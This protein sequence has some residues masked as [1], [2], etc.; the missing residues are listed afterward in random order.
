VAVVRS[1][2]LVVPAV[3]ALLSSACASAPREAPP[4]QAHSAQPA[5]RE[6]AADGGEEG[7]PPSLASAPDAAADAA[8][9]VPYP[10]PDWPTG[11]PDEHG[12][13]VEG[14]AA[15]AAV[16][17]RSQSFCLLVLR[18]G[19]LVYERYWNGRDAHSKDPSWSI[20]KSYTSALVGIAVGRGDIQSLDQR[21]A[22]FVPE[23]RNTDRAQI[24]IR[25][26]LRMTS[27]LKWDAFEDY[28]SLAT[29]AKDD[30]SFAIDRPLASTPGTSWTYDNGTVQVLERVFRAATGGSIEDYARA[31]LWSAIGADATWKHDPSGN[32]TTYANVLA[33]CRDHARLGYLY[34]HGG[35]WAGKE[36][37]PAAH[38]AATL[39]PSQ[40][41]NRAYGYLFWLN[42]E[43]PAL[44]AMSAAWPGRMVPFAPKDLFAARGFGNQF[45]DVIPS[46]DLMVVRFGQDPLGK[47]DPI[48]LASD[49][50]F[51]THDA[52]LA[53]ILDAVVK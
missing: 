3:I 45:I 52:I 21:A 20:A 46:L 51:S 25:D 19:T 22:D 24:T 17:E 38:V 11:A 13:R 23:W 40:N 28:V 5:P 16:A 44:D 6:I 53:P 48:T 4:T 47:F 26:L 30:T 50:R 15:A 43:T 33:S 12:L 39:T 42:S 2:T 1:S 8:L 7:R 36:I 18:H 49:A 35:R 27:G 9:G 37:V 31:H 34:L 29:L 41:I 32:P 14:L 10:T